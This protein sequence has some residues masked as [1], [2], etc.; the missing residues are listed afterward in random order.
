[1]DHVAVGA[2]EEGSGSAA[3]SRTCS[4]A[5]LAW[6]L[7]ELALEHNVVVL[8]VVERGLEESRPL[9]LAQVEVPSATNRG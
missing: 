1:M 2:V 8:A 6:A 5:S 9:V 3:R 7:E 4:V